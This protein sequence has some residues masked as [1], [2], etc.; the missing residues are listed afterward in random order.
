MRFFCVVGTVSHYG[1]QAV[2]SGNVLI[3][4]APGD[5]VRRGNRDLVELNERLDDRSVG[6]S[7]FKVGVVH[8]Y[9][10]PEKS[11]TEKKKEKKYLEFLRS[12]WS[13][14]FSC[15]WTHQGQCVKNSIRGLKAQ[16]NVTTLHVA[17]RGPTV[18]DTRATAYIP[19]DT[20]SRTYSI[21]L[22]VT[23]CD[24]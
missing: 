14:L 22:Y 4:C 18:A 1:G 17:Q 15:C 7:L 23:V 19:T 11:F 16:F 3:C 12:P 9:R 6:V 10:H 24:C 2:S 8:R 5:F 21:P 13:V 20:V